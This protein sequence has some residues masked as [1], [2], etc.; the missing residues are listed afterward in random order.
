MQSVHVRHNEI[1]AKSNAY[2][3]PCTVSVSDEYLVSAS[4]GLNQ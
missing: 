3:I 4:D 1:R 2:Q